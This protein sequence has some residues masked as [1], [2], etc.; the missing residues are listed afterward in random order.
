MN[1]CQSC[2]LPLPPNRCA[3]CKYCQAP[4]APTP[5]E[6]EI[7]RCAREIRRTWTPSIRRQRTTAAYRRKR[8]M[9]EMVK[10]AR[11]DWQ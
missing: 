4:W 6:E 9:V 2:G 8:W 11:K 7:E 1:L 3:F 10:D 5:S